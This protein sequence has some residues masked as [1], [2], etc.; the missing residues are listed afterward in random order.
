[1]HGLMPR[2]YLETAEG[3]LFAVVDYGIESDGENEND[4]TVAILFKSSDVV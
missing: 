2:D 4:Q 3:L 1:M